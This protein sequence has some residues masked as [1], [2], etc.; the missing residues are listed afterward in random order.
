[1]VDTSENHKLHKPTNWTEAVIHL[2]H[3][4]LRD[5]NR[6]PKFLV[7]G[8]DTHERLRQECEHKMFPSRTDVK[9]P[10]L[11]T[12]YGMDIRV[13][14]FGKGEEGRNYIGFMLE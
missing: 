9:I 10:E 14:N 5:Y 7:L 4:F 6:V 8:E 1:M 12:F 3:R 11:T 2:L 13:G